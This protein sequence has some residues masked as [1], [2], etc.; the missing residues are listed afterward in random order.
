MDASECKPGVIVQLKSGGPKMTCTGRSHRMNKTHME[1]QWF[2]GDKAERNFFPAES[3]VIP[4]ESEA[5]KK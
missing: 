4:S 1:C 5:K 3:L 2:S